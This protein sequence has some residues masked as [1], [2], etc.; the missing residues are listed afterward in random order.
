MP[1]RAQPKVPP[2]RTDFSTMIFRGFRSECVKT[3]SSPRRAGSFENPSSWLK[4]TSSIKGP[5]G[6]L[7]L[8]AGVHD[9]HRVGD[10]GFRV[11]WARNGSELRQ[12]VLELGG[13][14]IEILV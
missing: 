11:C 10:R 6:V 4:D 12:A 3:I 7:L 14:V 5:T 2:G 13:E 1:L 9:L 8:D